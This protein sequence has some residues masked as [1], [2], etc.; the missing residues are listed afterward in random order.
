LSA[1]A[2]GAIG[3]MPAAADPSSP[4][5]GCHGFY[6]TQ[7][8]EFSGDRGIQGDRDRRPRELGRQRRRRTGAFRGRSRRDGAGL[9]GCVLRQ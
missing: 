4:E 5:N 7:A 2:V 9:P 3:A 1:L 6:T 8:K